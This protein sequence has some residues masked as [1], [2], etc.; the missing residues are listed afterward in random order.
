MAQAASTILRRIA[1]LLLGFVSVVL[2]LCIVIQ[3]AMLAAMGWIGTATGKDWLRG[4]LTS[5]AQE[6]GYIITLDTASLTLVDGLKL[7]G[8][9]VADKD[10]VFLAADWASVRTGLAALAAKR[11]GVS[12]QA[13]E[14]HLSRLPAS[15][16]RSAEASALAAFTIPD[17]YITSLSLDRLSVRVLH[18]DAAVAGQ[19]MR[20][21]PEVKVLASWTDRKV[22]ASL[23]AA[24]EQSGQDT[25]AWLPRRLDIATQ[26]DTMG[27]SFLLEKADIENDSYRV[28]AQGKG[29]LDEL[30]LSVAAT[31]DQ[32]LPLA[33]VAGQA[34]V[35]ALITGTPSEPLIEARGKVDIEA[36]RA[37]GLDPVSFMLTARN[38]S[39][40]PAGHLAAEGRYQNQPLA[41]AAD[42]VY[43]A[44]VVTLTSI[45]GSAPA[46]TLS[47][48]MAYDISALLAEG[49][50]SLAA[51]DLSSYAQLIGAPVRGKATA[52]LLLSSRDKVQAV[53]GRIDLSDAAYETISVKTLKI[54]SSLPDVAAFW[55]ETLDMQASGLVVAPDLSVSSLSVQLKGKAQ[56]ETALSLA[57]KGQAVLPFQINGTAALSGLQNGVPSAHDIDLALSSGRSSLS[58]KGRASQEAIDFVAAS[59]GIALRDLPLGL[60][61]P[62]ADAKIAGDVRFSGTPAYPVMEARLALSPV[63][64]ARKAPAVTLSAL[65]HYTDGKLEASVTGKGQ[66]IRS[67]SAQASLPVTLSLYPAQFAMPETTPLTG[68]A[69]FDLNGETIAGLFLPFDHRFSGSLKGQADLSGSLASPVIG[70]SASLT[71]G[72]YLYQPYGV[73]LQQLSARASLSGSAIRLDALS[74]TDGEGGTLS[75]AG[76]VDLSAAAGT[77]LTLGLREFH[78]L[79]SKVADGVVS[80]DMALVSQGPGYLLKGKIRP[81]EVNLIIPEQFKSDIPQLNIVRKDAASS[82]EALSAI[83]LN[84]QVSAPNRIFV[85]GWGLDA[86]FG[87]ELDITGGLDAP[88]VNGSFKSI[89]GRYEE[90]GKRFTLANANLRFQGSVPPSPYLDIEATTAAG[91]VTASVLMTGSVTKPKIGFSSV[92]SL[93]ED[94]VLSRILFGKTMNRIT[95]FQAIQLAQT[96]QRF[97]GNG[98]GGLDP[99]GTLR[100]ATGLD[101]ISVE[102]DG[103]GET[104][105]GVGKYLTDKVYLQVKK[106]KAESSGAASLQVEVTPQ[107]SVESEVGQDAQ[108][109]GGVFWKWDY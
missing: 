99:L 4:H 32:L 13:G 1:R 8:V 55:P 12:L 97:S 48:T 73:S 53:S 18:L 33:G 57:A 38:L 96:L 22:T 87:G 106:G 66:G 31:S 54:Q 27:L 43:A 77:S 107:V 47:G 20:L 15:E 49:A 70:G 17:L 7:T 23:S 105:V 56:G 89:R 101:D 88:Q 50:I 90:F 39:S 5:L 41:L 14:V 78:L 10:G 34:E 44:P 86:E 75:G 37:R 19:E 108:A 65:G 59:R 6:S 2:V 35:N 92:P 21:S 25:I 74:A 60:S 81:G 62:L 51:G 76:A 28:T 93:P 36:A 103:S 67:L 83:L 24:I 84:L 40:Q 82:R 104:S 26:I 72:S 30:A 61:A 29:T 98:G 45:A 11:L 85:R 64:V 79:K 63:S 46:V 42:Y 102:T 68:R 109:G 52:A 95:P 3:L 69:A 100:A 71:G 9:K 16:E 91:D 58:V 94:E 80:A